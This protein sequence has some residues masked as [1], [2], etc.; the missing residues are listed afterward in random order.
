MQSC[1]HHII[2]NSSFSWWAAYL[3]KKEESIQIAP[4]IWYLDQKENNNVKEAILRDFHLISSFG[5]DD[6]N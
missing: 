3:G 6:G 5:E 2:A 4:S 1:K